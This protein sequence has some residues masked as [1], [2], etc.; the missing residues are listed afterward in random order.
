MVDECDFLAKDDWAG[1]QGARWL[2]NIGKFEAMLAP[3]GDALIARCG[4]EAG[5]RV[6]DLGCGGGATSRAI[7]EKVT[8]KGEVV[9]LDI[10]A[11]LIAYAKAQTP[12]GM[13]QNG[14][15]ALE[16]ICGDAATTSLA[17]APYDRLF[18]RFGSMFFD[19]PGAA[20]GNLHAMIKPGGRLDLAVWAHPRDNPWMMELMGVA[21]AHV[22][23]PPADPHAP[24][25]FAF[26]DLDHLEGVLGAGG[27]GSMEVA[28]YHADQAI[29]GPGTSPGGAVEF[30]LGSLGV[31]QVLAQQEPAVQA[32]ATAQLRALFERHYIPGKGVMLGCKVWLVSAAA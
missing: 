16:Y 27:F 17:R 10:S 28:A 25:P 29:G 22:D 31:G 23:I 15:P 32:A 2:N 6:I 19:D 14:A 20:F 13:S 12:L 9:G 7:A 26:A 3:I 30:V 1:E 8:P 21:R 4:F 11:D 18:S 5:E 24:G